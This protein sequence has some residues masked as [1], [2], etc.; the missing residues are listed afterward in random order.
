M[1]SDKKETKLRKEVKKFKRR[2]TFQKQLDAHLVEVT[3][4]KKFLL[5]RKGATMHTY[6]RMHPGNTYLS[7]KHTMQKQMKK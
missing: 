5:G 1:W 7:Q 3:H 6:A 4:F 2:S